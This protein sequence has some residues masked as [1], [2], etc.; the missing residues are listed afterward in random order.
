[1]VLATLVAALPDLVSTDLEMH[2]EILPVEWQ[3]V[4]KFVQNC[5]WESFESALFFGEEAQSRRI[6]SLRPAP[7]WPVALMKQGRFHP[8]HV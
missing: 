8:A 1:M 7:Q 4:T 6:G 3:A 5:D 2:V